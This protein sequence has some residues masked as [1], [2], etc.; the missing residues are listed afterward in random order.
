MHSWI[1]EQANR[2]HVAEL[3]SLGRPF[4]ARRTGLRVGRLRWGRARQ[5]QTWQ[6]V[7]AGKQ[8]VNVGF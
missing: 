1:S 4:G 5:S 8:R 7:T 3:R 6:G 2:E